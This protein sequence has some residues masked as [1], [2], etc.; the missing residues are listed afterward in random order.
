M[1]KL[2][3]PT[4]GLMVLCLC[5]VS[6][7][8]QV[9]LE[10]ALKA[11]RFV[12]GSW[13]LTKPDGSVDDV[14]CHLSPAKSAF[15]SES[16]QGLHIFGWDPKA[17]RLEVQSFMPNGTRSQAFFEQESETKFVGKSGTVIGPDGNEETFEGSGVFTIIDANTYQFSAGD[18]TWTAKRKNRN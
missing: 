5:S 2:G 7:A 8:E 6:R 14:N 16:K 4:V 1:S 15:V 9:T 10:Q 12:E 18:Q 3:F 13:T 11:W 17:K